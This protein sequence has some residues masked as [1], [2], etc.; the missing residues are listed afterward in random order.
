M[1]TVRT[2]IVSLLVL[3]I[4]S[5]G[6]AN[7]TQPAGEPPIHFHL[8]CL[9][10][11]NGQTVDCDSAARLAQFTAWVNDALSK[12]HSTFTIWAV[13]PT[14]QNPHLLFAACVPPHWRPTVWKAKA[15]FMA[16]ARQGVSGSQPGLSVPESCR[17]PGPQVSGSHRLAVSS[18]APLQADVWQ[19][20]ASGTAVPLHLAVVCDR[21]DSTLGA[22]CT[23]STLLR[24]FDRWVSESL[25]APAAT[26]SVEIV[27]PLKDA[28]QS[29]YHLSVPD[30]PVGERTAYALGARVELARLFSGPAA[31]YGSTIA[32]AISAT[33]RRLHERRGMYRLII[34]SDMR[35]LSAGGFNF[36]AVI[37]PPHD[38][39]AWLKQ[40]ALLADL[41]DIPVLVCGLHT[42]HF[43]QNNQ[44]YSTRLHD[45]WQAAFQSMG[46]PD[47]K[48][49]NSCDAAFAA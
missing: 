8:V 6:C 11:A 44:A 3:A 17:P 1:H 39:L 29:I 40:K 31:Q 41:R 46:A 18:A 38:F 9:A 24:L 47:V 5:T 12:P 23:T 20:V 21:S 43:G 25:L 33:V 4:F 16:G 36:E 15:A 2:P 28:L 37:P 32:E 35:Q 49:F 48:F 34:L 27:G 22:A 45:L 30:L 42:G 26:L 19:K 7:T 13:G 14:R 10:G